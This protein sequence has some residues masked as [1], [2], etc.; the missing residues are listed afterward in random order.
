MFTNIENLKILTVTSGTAKHNH[1]FVQK[2][3]YN[4]FILRLSG[5]TRYS[6]EGFHIDLNPGEI[7]F[8]P[9]ESQ[10]EFKVLTDEPCNY[11]SISFDA[12]TEGAVP[13]SYPFDGFQNS[14]EYINDLFSLWN[15]GNKAEKY[16][17]YAIFYNLLSYLEG[18]ENQDYI[19]KGK[20]SIISPAVSYLKLHIYDCSLNIETLHKLCGISGTYFRDIF[21]AHYGVGPQKYISSKRLSHAKTL[22]DSGDYGNISEI[23]LSSGYSD[24]LYFSR[25]FKKKYG[26]SPSQ[27]AKT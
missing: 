18:L 9:K 17:C 2:R 5:C 26:L 25:A 14:D 21:E 13:A 7:I 4:S 3:K 27:Y 16:R 10:Y 6:F 22:I 11:V 23:A 12:D 19:D 8:L 1:T 15:F 24:P 20:F